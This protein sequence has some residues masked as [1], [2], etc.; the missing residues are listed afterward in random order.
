[1]GLP[2]LV[3][4][5]VKKISQMKRSKGLFCSGFIEGCLALPDR[6]C[7]ESVV[8]SSA[9][10]ELEAIIVLGSLPLHLHA[11]SPATTGLDTSNVPLGDMN[12]LQE[13]HRP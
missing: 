10:T 5:E 2:K 3:Y 13:T 6:N 9:Q 7:M 4:H 8:Q 12:Q 1:M 11:T